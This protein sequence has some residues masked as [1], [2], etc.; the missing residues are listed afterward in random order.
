MNM[1]NTCYANSAV[2]ALAHLNRFSTALLNH[3]PTD[4]NYANVL[5]TQGRVATELAGLVKRL[6]E[7]EKQVAVP[8]VFCATVGDFAEQ[9]TLGAQHDSHEFLLRVL[10]YV[11]ED[12]NRVIS[13]PPAVPVFGEPGDDDED[14]SSRFWQSYKSRNDSIVVDLFHGL[15][16]S[17]LTCP[18]CQGVY[19]VF[20]PYSSISVPLPIPTDTTPPFVFVPFD[21]TQP[22]VRMEVEV[23]QNSSIIDVID[24]ICDKLRRRMSIAFAERPH[25]ATTLRWKSMIVKDFPESELLA[26]ELPECPLDSIMVPARLLAPT[27]SKDVELDAFFLVQMPA[28]NA[29]D[30]VA[31]AACAERFAPLF[32]PA[33][34]AITDQKLASLKQRIRD[35]G[36][37]FEDGA[38]FRCR[39]HSRPGKQSDRFE[40][41]EVVLRIAS[42]RIDV[43]LNPDEIADAFR[44]D[45]LRNVTGE[46]RTSAKGKRIT[47]TTLSECLL[48]FARE[49]IL[50]E[51]NPAFCPRC[52]T[53]VRASKKMDI[54][55]VPEV[56]VIHLKRFWSK[57]QHL[58]KLDIKVEFPDELDMAPF[59]ARPVESARYRLVSVIKHSGGLQGG[60]YMADILHHRIQ[61]WYRFDD[62]RVRLVTWNEVHSESGYVLFYESCGP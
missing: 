14:V 60:H 8:R 49:E 2:Q 45:L 47:K 50:D 39:I 9:F 22:R 42:Q 5:G 55:T 40:K 24:A 19:V 38:K 13:K 61:E 16:R 7:P 58:Q 23:V 20:D 32:A 52:R 43:L 51:A 33:A 31:E 57:R 54:W 26:F 1:G 56:L 34:G 15:Y 53:L 44:W 36:N 62:D 12:L 59:V 30:T 29:D 6:W 48:N 4:I 46:I 3:S 21:V 41:D 35:K 11:H 27:A 25:S 18:D 37:R 17:R 10:D 28:D